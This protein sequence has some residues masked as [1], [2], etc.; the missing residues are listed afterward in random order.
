MF[1]C[2]RECVRT[3]TF[4]AVLG[5]S[6]D[7]VCVMLCLW[8]C[9]QFGYVLRARLCTWYRTLPRPRINEDPLRKRRWIICRVLII[10]VSCFQCSLGDEKFIIYKIHFKFIIYNF[11]RRSQKSRP[12]IFQAAQ[13]I[14]KREREILTQLRDF[15][16]I[17]NATEKSR[18]SCSHSDWER[19]EIERENVF[20]PRRRSRTR[21]SRESSFHAE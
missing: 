19:C 18:Q 16:E 5:F 1:L 20:G 3:I 9:V 15:K 13:S 2:W 14:Y 17:E 7:V 11:Y 21:S 8:V 10:V 12:G 6:V 4:F